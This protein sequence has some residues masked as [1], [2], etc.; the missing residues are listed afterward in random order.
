MLPNKRVKLPGPVL[1][2]MVRLCARE[3]AV[4]GW[5]RLRRQSLARSLSAVR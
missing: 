1:S 3:V 2:G 4:G 5:A